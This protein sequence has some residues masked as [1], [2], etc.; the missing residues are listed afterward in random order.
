VGML[1]GF[2]TEVYLWLGTHVPWT[3]WV[4]IGTVITFAT[5]YAVSAL[6][7]PEST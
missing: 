3:W 7:N 5:G 6:L 2:A 1:L 4:A